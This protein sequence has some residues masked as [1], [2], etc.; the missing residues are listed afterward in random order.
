MTDQLYAPAPVDL[1]KYIEI[2]LFGKRPHIRGKRVPVALI[3]KRMSANHWTIT[4][5]AYDFSLS[6]AEV[7]AALLYYEEHVDEIQQQEN[8]EATFFDRMKLG[9]DS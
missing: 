6:E 4:E 5:T 7:L 9:N 3:A 2:R 8:D 1:Q